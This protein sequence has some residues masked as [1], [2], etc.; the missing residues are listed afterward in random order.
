MSIDPISDAI[1]DYWNEKFKD[2]CAVYQDLLL[3]D[4]LWLTEGKTSSKLFETT[5]TEEGEEDPT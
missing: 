2:N 5:Y 1:S 4:F 3:K